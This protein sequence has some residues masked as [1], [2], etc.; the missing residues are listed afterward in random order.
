[1]KLLVIEDDVDIAKLLRS[2]LEDA[3]YQVDLATDGAT[4][5]TL[6]LENS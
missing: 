1:M 2:G 6:A 4:G 5:L 3:C